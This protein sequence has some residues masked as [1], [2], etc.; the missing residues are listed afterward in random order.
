MRECE[1]AGNHIRVP[2][3]PPG[4]RQ[5]RWAGNTPNV[6]AIGLLVSLLDL[7]PD[8]LLST[9]RAVRKRLDLTR[10]V[11]RELV[12]EEWLDLAFQA[13]SGGNLQDQNVQVHEC[14]MRVARR[15]VSAVGSSLS[16]S[17]RRG[18]IRSP[19]GVERSDGPGHA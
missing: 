8:Q 3:R 18:V 5:S 7:T 17:Q 13:P 10:P 14:G 6:Q 11:E 19:I 4:A 12:E 1:P 2:D 15:P 9:T 16:P